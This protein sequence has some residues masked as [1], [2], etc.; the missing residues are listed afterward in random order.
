MKLKGKVAVV[1]GGNSGI[2]FAA[3][4]LFLAEG[5]R[6]VFTGRRPDAVRAAQEELGPGALGVVAD[7]ARSADTDALLAQV[8]RL[9]GRIDVLFLNAGVAPFAPLEEQTERGFD[10]VFAINVKGPYFTV[11]KALP[12]LSKGA[13]IVLNASV[14]AE[15]GF[16]TTSVY[17]ASKAAL[18]N[19]ARTLTAELAPRGIRVNSVSPGPIDT[20]IYGKLGKPDAEVEQM[21]AGFRTMVPLDR[22]GTSEELARAVLFLASD[23]SSFVTGADL[24]VDGGLAQV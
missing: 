17:S 8:E 1:T 14:V 4:K 21:A 23:D 9:H 18:R 13:S 22:F 19:L 12:L 20:P 2:G 11:Q 6:V 5:A 7:A 3:A 24:Q 15:K 10:E 16:P